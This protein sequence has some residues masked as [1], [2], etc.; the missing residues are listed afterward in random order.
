MTRYLSRITIRFPQC[1]HSNDSEWRLLAPLNFMEMRFDVW[2]MA[3]IKLHL[4]RA[5]LEN[6]ATDFKPR[7]RFQIAAQEPFYA[8]NDINC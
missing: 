8:N 6:G 3:F 4:K 7:Q 5:F 2:L 1:R